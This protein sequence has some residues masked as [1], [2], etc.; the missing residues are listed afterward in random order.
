MSKQVVK[1]LPVNA[2]NMIVLLHRVC[3]QWI[4]LYYTDRQIEA[5]PII[6][7]HVLIAL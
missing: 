5:V 4:I 6:L 7:K 1:V 3:N 2:I